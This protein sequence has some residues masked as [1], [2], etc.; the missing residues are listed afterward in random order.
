[1]CGGDFN[2]ARRISEKSN[3]GRFTRSMKVFNMLIEDLDLV[4]IP[5]KN[6]LFTWSDFRAH[7]TSTRIDRFLLSKG[8]LEGFKQV[9]LLRLS[10]TTSDHFP[11]LLK[12]KNKKWGPSPFRFENM[13]MDHPSFMDKVSSR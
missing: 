3:G 7:S 11:I 8:W 13:W 5:M 6:S 2:V 4:D 1:M 12:L 9:E 10:R